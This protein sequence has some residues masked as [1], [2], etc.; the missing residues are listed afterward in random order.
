VPHARR[1]WLYLI[2]AADCQGVTPLLHDWLTRH[3]DFAADEADRERLHDAYWTNHFR[4]RL[5]LAELRRVARALAETGIEVM[6]VKGARLATDYY[7]M[8]ALR[9]LGDLD[10][11][12]QPQDL[13]R[14]G[15]ALRA[16]HYREVDSP[17][18]Y[19]DDALLDVQSS[20]HCWMAHA[21][22]F[23]TLIEY[24][25][26]PLEPAFGRLT[27]L[28]PAVTASLR[29]HAEAVWLRCGAGRSVA[30][31][32]PWALMSP[33][34]LVLQIATHL[35]AKHIDFRLIWLHDLAR[36][37][38]GTPALDWDYVSKTSRDLRLTGPVSAALRASARLVGAPVPAAVLIAL[39]A[40]VRKSPLLT[41]ERWDYGRLQGHVASLAD[42]DLTVDGP[43]VWP[44]GS[45]LSRL[46]G[47]GPRLKMV[48]WVAL[49]CRAYLEDR[50]MGTTSSLGYLGASVERYAR[51]AARGA[52][53]A[54]RSAT[55]AAVAARSPD[56][57]A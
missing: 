21:D 11:L 29:R 23:D 32:R 9:P 34:D 31:D 45:A 20:E 25:T 8:P 40:D 51:H 42:R 1:D 4:N 6:P 5:L 38:G 17:H 30:P 14:L 57:S 41:L 52:L 36:V 12:V 54:A 37:V 46:S 48:R 27:D 43:G 47:W 33:E 24:R 35:A 10:L 26:V 15:D 53:R 7:P 2:R 18:T 3:P 13:S 56:R 39:D 50:G 49:P 55:R 16:L 44:I 22:G 19:M 28:D